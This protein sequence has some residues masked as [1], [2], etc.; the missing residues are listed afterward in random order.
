MKREIDLA[1][2]DAVRTGRI[3][4]AVV[5]VGD[6]AGI[7]HV[8][9]AGLADPVTGRAMAE[10]TIFQLASMTKA[11]T[12]V[13]A[14]RL[15][16]AG[17]LELDAPIAPL[18]PGL[19]DAQVL[20]GFAGGKPVLRTPRRPVT[21]RHLL[22][23]TSGLGYAFMNADMAQAQGEVRPG[24]LAAIAA[25]LL[26]DPGERWEYGVGTDWVGLAVEA[27]SGLSLG[28]YMARNVLEPLGMTDTSFHLDAERLARRAALLIRGAEGAW[29]RLPLEFGGGAAAEFEAG[30]GGLMGTGG[31]YLRFLRMLL[32]GGELDGVRVL[33]ADTVAEMARNQVGVLRAGAMGSIMPRFSLPFDLFPDMHTGWGLGFLLNPDVGPNGRGAGSLAWAGVANTYYWADAANDVAAVVMMQ[34][35]PFGDRAALDLLGAVERAVYGRT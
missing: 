8:S 29:T 12:S 5:L 18:L 28:D 25:P 4:G 13:A 2:A 1:L 11:V 23:H 10:D 30:G 6:A 22:T 21:L 32:R 7:R 15:V 35:L 24:S 34:F 20:T 16:E 19:A 9:A 31:D 26:F 27:A 3:A 17:A 14:M 33:R